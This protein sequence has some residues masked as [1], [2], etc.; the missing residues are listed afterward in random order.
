[1]ASGYQTGQCRRDRFHLGSSVG[2]GCLEINTC[3]A[4]LR[5]STAC[6]QLSALS[7]QPCPP[8]T[9][10]QVNKNVQDPAE[11]TLGK[12]HQPLRKPQVTRNLSSPSTES[13]FSQKGFSPRVETT[14]NPREHTSRPILR[15]HCSVPDTQ[16]TEKNP[17]RAGQHASRPI[18]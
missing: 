2:P 9:F 11:D 13:S 1:M 14:E 5:S 18:F 10:P 8:G 7:S 3:S 4:A 12:E 17:P 6:H 15:S 16:G